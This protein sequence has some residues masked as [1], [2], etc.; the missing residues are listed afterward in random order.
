MESKNIINILFLVQVLLLV[1]IGYNY[2]E[3]KQLNGEID[4]LNGKTD[5]LD[6]KLKLI[7]SKINSMGANGDLE[8]I[9]NL[10][11]ENN[12]GSQD[13]VQDAFPYW[14]RVLIINA[15][16]FDFE[17]NQFVND[18]Y[19]KKEVRVFFTNENMN[20]KSQIFQGMEDV[21]IIVN[22]DVNNNFE[23]ELI[24]MDLED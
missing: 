5:L 7:D 17:V 6:S 15:D 4:L 3:N 22:K 14:G 1:F 9:Q 16:S 19:L 21:F 10:E 13:V 18:L 20:L 12:G 2:F 8:N 23:V 24:D 11:N